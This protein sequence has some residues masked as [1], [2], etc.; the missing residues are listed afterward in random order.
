MSLHEEALKLLNPSLVT[1]IGFLAFQAPFVVITFDVFYPFYYDKPDMV[2][3]CY[4]LAYGAGMVVINEILHDIIFKGRTLAIAE[5]TKDLRL[6]ILLYKYFHGILALLIVWLIMTTTNLFIENY[7]EFLFWITYIMVIAV[8][9]YLFKEI[10]LK[11]LK[12][13][14]EKEIAKEKLNKAMNEAAETFK[15]LFKK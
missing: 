12:K 4:I 8:S 3:Y 6:I 13:R 11:E 15:D 14:K 5:N 9:K 2:L 7:P 1:V 10:T